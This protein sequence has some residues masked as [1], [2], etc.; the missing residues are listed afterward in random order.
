MSTKR[1]PHGSERRWAVSRVCAVS[2][3]AV[4]EAIFARNSRS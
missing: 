1:L 3:V 4:A 2:T